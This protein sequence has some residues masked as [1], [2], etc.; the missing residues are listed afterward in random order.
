MTLDERKMAIAYADMLCIGE[1]IR[2]VVQIG[3]YDLL[4]DNGKEKF[5][6]AELS[7]D[8]VKGELVAFV[9]AHTDFRT[10]ET[11]EAEPDGGAE[12]ETSISSKKRELMNRL[13]FQAIEFRKAVLKML[14]GL[15][16]T[17]LARVQEEGVRLDGIL[18]EINGGKLPYRFES[19]VSNVC[20]T[21]SILSR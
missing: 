21:A 2:H 13:Y 5:E 9:N 16:Q 10:C 11:K 14:D 7:V 19:D 12:G 6:D 1:L 20:A 4:S 15:S 17:R 3:A 18:S 8:R